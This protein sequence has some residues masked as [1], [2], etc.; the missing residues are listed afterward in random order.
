LRGQVAS[1]LIVVAL[2]I[3]A[4]IGY[5]GNTAAPRTTT[6]TVIRTYTATTTLAGESHVERCV[7][8]VYTVWAVEEVSNS[9]TIRGTST[10]SDPVQTYQ[11]SASAEHTVGFETTT[12]VSY[13]GTLSGPIALW[14]G[15]AC[16]FISG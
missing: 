14:N 15:T 9:N 8:T 1:F 6:E 10:Q 11:T 16:T 4:G 12:M 5:F 3:G 7:V 13:T 2:I